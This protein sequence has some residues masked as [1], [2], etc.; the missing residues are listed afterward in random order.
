MIQIGLFVHISVILFELYCTHQ[1]VPLCEYNND[2]YFIRIFV[3]NFVLTHFLFN[4]ISYVTVKY[5]MLLLLTNLWLTSVEFYGIQNSC[6]L[7]SVW[8]VAL[9][10]D[11]ATNHWV[12]NSLKSID[13]N[14]NLVCENN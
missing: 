8:F 7:P 14:Y 4:Q 6:Q 12:R 9:Q 13:I 10:C 3:G 1:E 2:N 11:I 5:N